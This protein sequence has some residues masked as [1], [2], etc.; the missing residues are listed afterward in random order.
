[1]YGNGMSSSYPTGHFNSRWARCSNYRKPASC[2]DQNT[3]AKSRELF[4]DIR[5][6]TGTIQAVEHMGRIWHLLKWV[7]PVA[8]LVTG[9]HL[10]YLNTLAATEHYPEDDFLAQATDKVGLD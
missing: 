5:S 2:P 7:S 10:Y 1:M 9:S 8:V 4:P 3:G 6:R